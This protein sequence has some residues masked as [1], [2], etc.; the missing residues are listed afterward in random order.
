VSDPLASVLIRTK[1][2][3]ESIGRLLDLLAAQTVADRLETIVVDS[4]SQDR[5]VEIARSAGV[6]LIEIP[7]R[8]FTYGRALN[9]GSA[10]ARAPIVIPLSAHAFPRHDRWAERMLAV[11]ED[12]RVACACG[13]T[14]DP[15]GQ[16]IDAPF[17]QDLEHARRNPL[18]GYSNSAGG[19]R[20][21]LWRQRGF[22][23]DMPFT[24]DKEW[25]WHWLHEGWRV[26]FDPELMV[27][28]D[29]SHDPLPTLYRRARFA[30]IGFG[31]Y[32]DL[33]P[34]P[35]RDLVREWW[36]DVGAH[37]TPLRG[38][39]SPYRC[40]RLLGKYAGRRKVAPS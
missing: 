28:H 9:I 17:Q 1:D 16:P 38:R 32:L 14:K 13:A 34:Y 40:A 29:H 39:L 12:E 3:E 10:A 35:V 27:D 4:G 37:A 31:M 15:S 2:E 21:A 5:T 8:E 7:A 33:P 26:A 24:E 11:F 20:T 25:A 30:W 6:R 36:L 18:Y 19:Y 23:E 22:R